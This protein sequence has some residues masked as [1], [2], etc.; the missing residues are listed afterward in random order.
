MASWRQ[1]TGKQYNCYLLKWIC[2]C[3]ENDIKIEQAD[4]NDGLKFLTYLYKQGVGYSTINTARSA[5][6]AVINLGNPRTFGEHPLVTRFLK[7]VF[8]LKPSLPRY[9]VVWDVGVVLKYM[10]SMPTMQDMT[11]AMLTKKLTTLLA[12]LT[13]QRCQTLKNLDLA[14]MQETDNQ[15]IFTIREKLK[16]TRAGKHLD[17]IEITS[18]PEDIRL[19]P[20]A[21]LRFYITK[22]SSTR[23]HTKLLLSYVK[24]YKP[25]TNSTIG[26]WVKSLIKDSGIDTKAFSAH[27]SRTAASSYSFLSGLPLQDILKAGGWSTTGTFA[28]H[29]NKPI[30]SNFGS[31][32]LNHFSHANTQ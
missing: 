26:R 17:P 4:V 7:G 5:L 28:K 6:S 24:P 18:Y 1:N 12:L 14:Y 15:F 29:Y 13:A 20:V 32:I 19:C 8:E 16:T 9:T 22:T 21:H 31:S 3:Q 11:L 27:S 30:D 23:E 2:F 10:Q 25:V